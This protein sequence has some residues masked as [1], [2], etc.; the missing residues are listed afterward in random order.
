[1]VWF[2]YL[3]YLGLTFSF[4]VGLIAYKR[5]QI[6]SAHIKAVGI[7]GFIYL[8]WD[9]FAAWRHHW[10]F[11]SKYISGIYITNQPLEEVLFFIVVPFLYIILWNLDS[12]EKTN[13]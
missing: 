11:G 12:E 6:T 7:S 13:A 8:M 5:I 1:M 2:E 4:T 9:I 10:D 3:I